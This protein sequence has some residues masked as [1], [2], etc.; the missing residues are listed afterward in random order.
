MPRNPTAVREVLEAILKTSHTKASPEV[1]EGIRARLAKEPSFEM[2]DEVFDA[3]AKAAS[4]RLEEAQSLLPFARK[5]FPDANFDD[6]EAILHKLETMGESDPLGVDVLLPETM[7][8]YWQRVEELKLAEPRF[9]RLT[10]LNQAVAKDMTACRHEMLEALSDWKKVLERDEQVVDP[11]AWD[12]VHDLADVALAA[13]VRWRDDV[14]SLRKALGSNPS[15][16]TDKVID[17]AREAARLDCE[18]QKAALD[19]RLKE[20]KSATA[21]LQLEQD[22]RL[23]SGDEV[24]LSN[25]FNRVSKGK[26]Y[27]K[28]LDKLVKERCGEPPKDLSDAKKLVFDAKK[29]NMVNYLE[30]LYA[31]G[32]DKEKQKKAS[33]QKPSAVM[34]EYLKN[35]A[36]WDT[37]GA[38]LR[39]RANDFDGK[40]SKAKAVLAE[41]VTIGE[42]NREVNQ[43][44]VR[45][46]LNGTP[47]ATLA[48][49]RTAKADLAGVSLSSTYSGKLDALMA[50]PTFDVGVWTR[51]KGLGA[52]KN[53]FLSSVVAFLET[54]DET[55]ARQVAQDYYG[56]VATTRPGNTEEGRIATG[57]AARVIGQNKQRTVHTTATGSGHAYKYHYVGGFVRATWELH[58]HEGHANLYPAWKNISNTH[59]Y[60]AN[61]DTYAINGALRGHLT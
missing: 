23:S 59:E 15:Q 28:E 32:E 6:I 49:Y 57:L 24:W 35:E 4:W 34:T 55:I 2:T 48:R 58:V 54:E 12:A 40:M 37:Y 3:L 41:L 44:L 9:Q 1:I 60:V 25:A 43:W 38:Y 11:A 22:A 21:K 10:E 27:K 20:L 31:A 39:E 16:V 30:A 52:T 50:E 42:A 5:K 13:M 36:G 61:R 19:Q 47:P 33:K 53:L 29:A 26:N 14:A 18:A 45:L 7:E 51:L 56:L 8:R 17:E 46:A